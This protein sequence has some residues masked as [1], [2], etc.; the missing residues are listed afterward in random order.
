MEGLVAEGIVSLIAYN[1]YGD[2][3]ELAGVINTN[4]IELKYCHTQSSLRGGIVA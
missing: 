1:I 3:A 2:T 4:M